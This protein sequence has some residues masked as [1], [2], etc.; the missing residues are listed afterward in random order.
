MTSFNGIAELTF[1]G[2]EADLAVG[3]VMA[4]EE[5]VEESKIEVHTDADSVDEEDGEVRSGGV[6]DVPIGKVAD[7]A[8]VAVEEGRRS[9]RNGGEGGR[10][11]YGVELEWGEDAQVEGQLKVGAANEELEGYVRCRATWV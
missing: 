2:N 5:V 6:W 8:A 3:D 11:G 4:G 1:E 7:W 10:Y 9:E